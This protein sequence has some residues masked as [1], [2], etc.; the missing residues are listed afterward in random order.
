VSFL[1]I[2]HPQS[3]EE[4]APDASGTA[5]TAV[6]VGVL[7]DSMAWDRAA[8]HAAYRAR[9]S[10]MWARVRPVGVRARRRAMADL[11][12]QA[13]WDRTKEPGGHPPSADALRGGSAPL[14]AARAI[15]SEPPDLEHELAGRGD[16]TH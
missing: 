2:L 9:P 7:P 1:V 8:R 5:A 4:I 16:P 15:S 14:W 6:N 10:S 12:A 11:L 13:P 3:Y